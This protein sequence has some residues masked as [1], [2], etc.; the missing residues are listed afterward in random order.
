MRVA[1]V[2]HQ[3]WSNTSAAPCFWYDLGKLRKCEGNP[4]PLPL[5]LCP[6]CC[7]YHSCCAGNGRL[8]RGHP[9]PAP[10]LAP[11][12]QAET[13][14]QQ[15]TYVP[16]LASCWRGYPSHLLGCASVVFMGEDVSRWDQLSPTS[17]T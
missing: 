14:R 6:L 11:D 7:R 2:M 9:L 5:Q 8:H 1:A 3:V 13:S 15:Q 10:H 17:T 12:L 4:S 16:S